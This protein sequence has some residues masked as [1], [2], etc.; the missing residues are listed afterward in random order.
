MV[1][2]TVLRRNNVHVTGRGGTPMVFAHG[3]GCDQHMLRLVASSFADD[4]KLVLYDLAGS[5]RSDLSA[6]DR[7]KYGTLQGH[8]TDLS[9]AVIVGHSVSAM[10]AVLAANRAPQL[11]SSLIT[12]APSPCYLNDG[13]YVGGFERADI[14]G[15]LDFLDSNFLGWSTKMAPAIMG[16]PDQPELAGELTNSFCRTD[17]EIAKHFGRVTFLSDHRTDANALKHPALVLQCGDDIIPPLVV[18]EWL[19]RNM[20]RSE[21]VVMNA[22]DHCPHLSAPAETIAAMR[23]FLAGRQSPR[24]V[25]P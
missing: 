10:T 21:L 24:G 3:Y 13:D 14:D 23:Q 25:K 8:A 9:N 7:H 17:P 11:F 4:Y 20:E 1:I 15:L 16:V 2:M 18:G 12:V 19:N 22:T 5:G 6:Y